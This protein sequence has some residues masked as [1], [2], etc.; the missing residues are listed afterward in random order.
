M[1][2]LSNECLKIKVNVNN[3]PEYDKTICIFPPLIHS[4]TQT[5]Q[6]LFHCQDMGNYTLAVFCRLSSFPHLIF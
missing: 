2:I 4:Y 1:D 3:I 5:F 6:S